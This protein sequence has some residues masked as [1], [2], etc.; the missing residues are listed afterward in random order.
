[1]TAIRRVLQSISGQNFNF[2]PQLEQILQT[3]ILEALNDPYKAATEEALT[4]LA[5]LLYNQP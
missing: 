2:Y 5:E 1:M 3:P 4:C